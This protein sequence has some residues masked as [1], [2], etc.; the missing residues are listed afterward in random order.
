MERR[1]EALA[2]CQTTFFSVVQANVQHTPQ[3]LSELENPGGG[4]AKVDM[5]DRYDRVLSATVAALAG[6]LS[7][8]KAVSNEAMDGVLTE[9][10]W[11]LLQSP[12]PL[13]RRAMYGLLFTLVSTRPAWTREHLE[14]VRRR[15]RLRLC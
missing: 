1:P 11:R 14:Q 7:E 4:T 9:H 15:G 3:S 2:F 6:F 5:Q 12:R 8:A 10:V 13:I